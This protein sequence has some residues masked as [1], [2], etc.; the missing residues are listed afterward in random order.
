MS[1]RGGVHAAVAL[2]WSP[3]LLAVGLDLVELVAYE[4]ELRVE[5]HVGL[6]VAC[7][8]LVDVVHTVRA[9][10]HGRGELLLL[11]SRLL[12][13]RVVVLPLR[14]VELPLVRDELSVQLLQLEL[15]DLLVDSLFDVAI[16]SFL[17]TLRT[18]LTAVVSSSSSRVRCGRTTRSAPFEFDGRQVK[19]I[20]VDRLGHSRLVHNW[21]T[22][23]GRRRCH[24]RVRHVAR[25]IGD[26]V[27]QVIGDWLVAGRVRM[28][29][30]VDGHRRGCARHLN[31]AVGRH[32]LRGRS[33]RW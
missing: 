14:F 26:K 21:R 2:V 15:L 1:V 4:L 19:A 11:D 9:H 32:Q 23:C 31:V 24:K 28:R 8:L 12:V 18:A 29:R 20:G 6:A 17:F 3:L 25:R 10:V 13:L 7:L 27:G 16:H 22:D 33:Q 5:A 30:V